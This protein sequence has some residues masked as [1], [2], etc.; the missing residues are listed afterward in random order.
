VDETIIHTFG[1]YH[2][3]PGIDTFVLGYG[4]QAAF[5]CK[6]GFAAYYSTVDQ[7]RRIHIVGDTHKGIIASFVEEFPDR[8]F[9][10]AGMVPDG[11]IRKVRESSQRF[12]TVTA[13][14]HCTD[15]SAWV[16]HADDTS[17]GR[18]VVDHL[19]AAGY[20]HLACWG[21]WDIGLRGP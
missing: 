4:S 18:Q 3:G 9:I 10:V 15:P 14:T 8:P 5:E 17:I 19:H 2:S 16:I 6:K 7:P 11:F 13:A 12:T 20:R 1:N 21:K